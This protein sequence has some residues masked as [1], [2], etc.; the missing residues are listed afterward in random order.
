VAEL[1]DAAVDQSLPADAPRPKIDL[2]EDL[3][4]AEADAGQVQQALENLLRN[5]LESGGPEA[6]VTISARNVRVREGTSALLPGSYVQIAFEDRG[7]AIPPARHADVFDP[8]FGAK[9]TDSALALAT[10]L[11][12]ASRHG[13]TIT[14]ESA[15]DAGS[16]FAL[17]LPASLS[18]TQ[19][20][21]IQRTLVAG[22]GRRVLV[23]DDEEMV[24]RVAR[25]MLEAMGFDVTLTA[26][27]EEAITRY[28]EARAAAQPFHA[29][30]LDLTVPGG[31]GGRE[32]LERLR[33]LDPA[34]RAIVASGYSDDAV[35]SH[36][37]EHG[38]R[39]VLAKPYQ[40]TELA[41]ALH[42]TL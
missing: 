32:T 26:N 33:A 24:R 13:G 31:L 1:L 17:Y 2:P 7:P 36:Y 19:E 11:S 40:I 16:V 6:P 18:P 4:A 42:R 15:P 37:A 22:E 25:R 34:V 5:A 23:M 14:V 30:M 20:H 28:E 12:I 27:G 29:V 38:F 35:M 8:Y 21:A 9:N 39:A 41:A 10:A 3:W